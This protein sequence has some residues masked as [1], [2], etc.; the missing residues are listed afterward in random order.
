M[1]ARIL[2]AKNWEAKTAM[3]A[4]FGGPGKGAQAAA[5]QTALVAE[6]ANR[7]GD[8][9]AASL[10]DLVKAF[11]TVPHVVLVKAAHD[12]GYPL[13]L[14]RLCLAAYRLERA[15]GVDGIFSRRV[16]ATRGITAGA[17]FAALEL[18]LLLLDL[19]VVLQR[20]W[21]PELTIQ[22]YVDDLTLAMRNAPEELIRKMI[23][24]TNFVVL[25]LEKIF[26]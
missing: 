7:D 20:K 2:V 9:F 14:L 21:A 8:A 1:R 18:R 16:T 23:I 12:K 13:V 25:F 5:Y 4:I 19:I 24:I 10:L 15:I 11:E 6:T 26:S 3:P 22:L 17:G